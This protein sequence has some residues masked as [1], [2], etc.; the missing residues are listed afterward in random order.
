MDI[1]LSIDTNHLLSVG[2]FLNFLKFPLIYLK[3]LDILKKATSYCCHF[4]TSLLS[5][6]NT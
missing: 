5:A 2:S 6:Y 4:F 3:F 1:L